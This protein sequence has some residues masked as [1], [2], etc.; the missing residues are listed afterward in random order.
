MRF[1]LDHYFTF[2]LLFLLNFGQG[3][4]ELPISP[5]NPPDTPSLTL[6]SSTN[7]YAIGCIVFVTGTDRDNDRLAYQFEISSLSSAA[8]ALSD[9]STYHS[10]GEKAAFLIQGEEGSYNIRVR[11]RDDMNELSSYSD[12]IQVTFSNISPFSPETPSGDTL[13]W[14]GST[15]EFH[16][17]GADPEGDLISF[18][19]DPGNGNFY[20][21]WSEWQ[22]LHTDSELPIPHSHYHFRYS[23]L[24]QGAFG[25][26]VQCMDQNGNTSG[27]SDALT[28]HV[29]SNLKLIGACNVP[30][31]AD[32]LV[33][34]ENH[35]YISSLGA[36]LQ[37]GDV[38][39]P[40]NPK[41]VVG[42]GG[43]SATDVRCNG[44]AAFLL[45]SWLSRYGSLYIYDVSKPAVPIQVGKMNIDWPANFDVEENLV[46]IGTI[47]STRSNRTIMLV[48]VDDPSN[49]QTIAISDVGKDFLHADES[50]IILNFPYMFRTAWSIAGNNIALYVFDVSNMSSP[51]TISSID[52]AEEAIFKKPRICKG[53]SG[54]IY[55]VYNNHV[56]VV[57]IRNPNNP[58]IIAEVKTKSTENSDLHWAGRYL[59]V[60]EGSAGIELFDVSTPG[61]PILIGDI[62]TE[63]NCKGVYCGADYLY[64]VC[65]A[66]GL[67]IF[68]Y[69]S[70]PL[71]A[72][73]VTQLI[74]RSST[75]CL[76]DNGR[77]RI[78]P[79]S[80]SR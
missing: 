37:I 29:K 80:S 36:G 11:S 73:G 38:S 46:V 51:K 15:G 57:D 58:T 69:P 55:S 19:F 35:A 7:S 34:D 59:A 62:K 78:L 32:R 25:L 18:R 5:N 79:Y 71:Y 30:G 68:S 49:P 60:A 10:S 66:N 20:S 42:V 22:T 21:N 1:S 2:L 54:F 75:K 52:I 13:L 39:D 76:F 47:Y 48:N 24:S 64:A 31:Q 53:P 50:E 14:A 26:K 17:T 9:W 67:Q 72:P 41:I 16:T 63:G 70:S 65:G 44:K 27:W 77:I 4:V 61:N 3:C 23:Y 56:K 40:R 45:E 8:S 43:Y 6:L 74:K 12:K 33:V 28:V